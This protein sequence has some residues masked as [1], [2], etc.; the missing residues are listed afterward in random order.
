MVP[1]WDLW[2][3]APVEPTRLVARLDLPLPLKFVDQ[4]DKGVET[5]GLVA[6]EDCWKS[7]T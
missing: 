5:R 4:V 7:F 3:E 2:D 6:A 1:E